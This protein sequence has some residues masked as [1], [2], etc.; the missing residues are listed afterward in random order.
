MS[1]E[2]INKNPLNPKIKKFMNEDV[3]TVYYHGKT[4]IILKDVFQ[5]LGRVKDNGSWTDVKNKVKEFL[6][7]ID[8]E[9]EYVE[10]LDVL[11]KQGKTKVVKEVDLLNIEVLPTVL[12]QFKP[13]QTKPE[14]VKIWG[15]FMKVVHKIL[16]E[17]KLQEFI[18][19]DREHQSL[20]SDAITRETDEEMQVI[21]SNVC[22]LMAKILGVYPDIKKIRKEDLKI[23]NADTSIDLLEVRQ[24][25]L[26]MYEQMLLM[27]MSKSEIHEKILKYIK[28]KY[29]L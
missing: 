13:P 16:E 21:N 22:T 3:R 28:K 19:K 20:V 6:R 1:K 15:N 27:D 4:Y 17:A 23:Y 5:V 26:N 9:K 25:V 24:E 7:L 2:P 10:N 8:K 12:T 29:E 14:K 18:L 11:L